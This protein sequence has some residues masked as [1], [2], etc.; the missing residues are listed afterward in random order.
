MSWTVLADPFPQRLS[1]LLGAALA[2][3]AGWSLTDESWIS[4]GVQR[5]G[6]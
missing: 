5:S 4:L 6:D 1:A 2:Q 3:D